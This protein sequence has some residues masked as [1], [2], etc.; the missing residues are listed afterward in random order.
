MEKSFQSFF[1]LPLALPKTLSWGPLIGSEDL[2]RGD[3]SQVPPPTPRGDSPRLQLP[4]TH[5]ELPPPVVSRATGGRNH[6]YQAG[7]KAMTKQVSET[8]ALEPCCVLPTPSCSELSAVWTP[9]CSLQAGCSL[10][11]AFL[12]LFSCSAVSWVI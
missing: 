7:G 4:R 10:R 1:R 8:L 6:S 2:V 12:G 11:A 5:L 9:I 3:T